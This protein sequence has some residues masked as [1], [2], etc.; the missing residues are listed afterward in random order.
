MQTAASVAGDALLDEAVKSGNPA[1][2]RYDHP[3]FMLF[4]TKIIRSTN[5]TVCH[6][7][8]EVSVISP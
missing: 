2:S 5:M 7:L 1:K 8:V 4:P 6:F 3:T